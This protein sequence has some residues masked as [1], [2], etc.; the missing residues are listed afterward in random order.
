[1]QYALVNGFRAEPTKGKKGI[2]EGCNR[3]VIA[4]CGSVKIHHWA[5]KNIVDCDSWYEPET[6]WHRDWKNN[7]PMEYREVSFTNPITNEKHRA[8]IHTP[9]GV[10][11]EFQN[12][13]ISI[14]ELRSRDEFYKS[15]IWVVNG[16]KFK[17]N[18]SLTCAIPMP[19]SPLLSNFSIAG[20]PK[21]PKHLKNGR[22]ALKFFRNPTH[23]FDFEADRI[24]S[25]DDLEG[26]C[27]LLDNSPQIYWLF[28]WQYRRSVWFGSKSHVFFDFGGECLYWL[29]GRPQHRAP[30]PLWYVH[31]VKK[32]DFVKKYA[33]L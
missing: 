33:S 13:P 11:I 1:M 26:V 6:Q 29:K 24:L 15:L 5:H 28:D 9:K 25:L 10:T 17:E 23:K 16:A 12:S 2:C 7:F 14:D 31:V 30:S 20:V 19:T 21:Y 32:I 3:E 18:F 27:E 8:D 4:K 22:D